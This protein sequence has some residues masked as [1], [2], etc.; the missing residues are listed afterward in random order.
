[1]MAAWTLLEYLMHRY[2]FHI[3]SDN[4]IIARFRYMMH[5]IHHDNPRDKNRLIMPPVPWFLYT[6][7]LL[8]LFYLVMGNYAFAFMPGV[9]IG[10]CIY[11]YI[12]YQIH[13]PNP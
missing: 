6:A 12:H 2:L 11:V 13:L 5:G 4:K 9:L 7:V 1:G 8:S 3:S 10:Y